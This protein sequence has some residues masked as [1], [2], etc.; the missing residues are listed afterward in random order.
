MR[1]RRLPRELPPG[2]DRLGFFVRY[3]RG[4]A[5]FEV[6]DEAD[7]LVRAVEHELRQRRFARSGYLQR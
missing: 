7:D 2:S 3:E 4:D 6:S 5:D 1:R